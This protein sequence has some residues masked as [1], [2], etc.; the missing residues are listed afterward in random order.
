MIDAIK[1]ERR[2]VHLSPCMDSLSSHKDHI[3]I[4]IVGCSP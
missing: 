3:L 4:I 2:C 1:D